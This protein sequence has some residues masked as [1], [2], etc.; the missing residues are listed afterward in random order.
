MVSD[1]ATG[2]YPLM[3]NTEGKSGN[4]L[5][6]Q[7]GIIVDYDDYSGDA[8][9]LDI[10][11]ARSPCDIKKIITSTAMCSGNETMYDKLSEYDDAFFENRSLIMISRE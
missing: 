7:T 8:S 9:R 10:R 5:P 4:D 2:T 6:F 3:E 11:I 1:D